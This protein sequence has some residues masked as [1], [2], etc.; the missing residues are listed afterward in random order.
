MERL[1]K[2]KLM[3]LQ[4]RFNSTKIKTY[5]EFIPPWIKNKNKKKKKIKVDKGE[6]EKQL[7]YYH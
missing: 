1:E 4:E 5:V 6:E 2:E 3:K 7:L